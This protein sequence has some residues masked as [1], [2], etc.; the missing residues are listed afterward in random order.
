MYSNYNVLGFFAGLNA[1]E[2]LGGAWDA[3][4]EAALRR[5]AGFLAPYAAEPG[6]WPHPQLDGVEPS[7]FHPVA[8]QAADRWPGDGF[9]RFAAAADP[10]VAAD[11]FFGPGPS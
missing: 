8:A 7:A 1:L 11:F 5:A 4:A 3:A 6:A 9:D 10:V 2:A